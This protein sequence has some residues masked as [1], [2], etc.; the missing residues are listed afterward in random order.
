[1]NLGYNVVMLH[2]NFSF[3]SSAECAQN[4][5]ISGRWTTGV[6]FTDEIN[7]KFAI[8]LSVCLANLLYVSQ[9]LSGI[10]DT[11]LIEKSFRNCGMVHFLPKTALQIPTFLK[12]CET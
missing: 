2:V 4:L 1:M 7:K 5:K 11:M 8:I 12:A 10:P 3:G 6:I 9:T